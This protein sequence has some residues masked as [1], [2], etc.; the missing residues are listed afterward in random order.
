MNHE[1]VSD[2]D[3][4]I[5]RIINGGR[6]P[7]WQG[8]LGQECGVGLKAIEKAKQKGTGEGGR[9]GCGDVFVRGELMR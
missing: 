5:L 9:G 4:K 7:G 1:G 8:P 6:L 3:Q 2:V